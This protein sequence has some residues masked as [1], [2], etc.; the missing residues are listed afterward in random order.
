MT[1]EERGAQVFPLA[2]MSPLILVLTLPLLLIPVVF[3]GAAVT[4]RGPLLLGPG[5]FVILLY[6]WTWTRMRPTSFVVTGG[7]VEV[8]W[9]LRRERLPREAIVSVR[10]IDRAALRREVGWGARVGVGGLWGAFGW[11]WT[12]RR[13]VVRMYISRTSDFVWIETGGRPWMITPADP[14]RFIALFQ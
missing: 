10:A 6:V 2:P 12:T 3:I 5:G 7:G 14:D 4:G 13:G 8:V 1:T 11:L 9:P